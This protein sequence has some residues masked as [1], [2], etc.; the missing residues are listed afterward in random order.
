MKGDVG[1]LGGYFDDNGVNMMHDEWTSLMSNTSKA[2]FDMVRNEAPNM[3]IDL[4]SCG[5]GPVLLPAR[6]TP[7]SVKQ[8]LERFKSILRE[9]LLKQNY[10]IKDSNIV[11]IEG[12][13]G[14]PIPAFN[15]T[16]MLYHTGADLPFVF[17]NP[18]GC[19]EYTPLSYEDIL[20][21]DHILFETALDFICGRID[22]E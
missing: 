21:I 19:I 2:I 9:Q 1:I 4:H 15:R 14:K 7:F 6:Y 11:A 20:N 5:S 18:H 12:E 22:G 10:W 13:E 3:Y 16:S 17:E 8:R